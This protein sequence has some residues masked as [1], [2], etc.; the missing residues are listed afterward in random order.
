MS[1]AVLPLFGCAQ[2]APPTGSEQFL[3][4]TTGILA[5]LAFSILCAAAW[6]SRDRR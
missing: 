4:L 5:V 1:A 3:T 6:T 2:C